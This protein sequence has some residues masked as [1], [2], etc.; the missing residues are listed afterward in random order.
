MC[1]GRCRGRPISRSVTA[2]TPRASRFATSSRTVSSILDAGT[3]IVGLSEALGGA[4]RAVPILLSHYHWD[5]VQGLPFF[6]QFFQP[7]WDISITGPPLPGVDAS[8]AA[9]LF[10][11]PHFPVPLAELASPPTVSFVESTAFTIGGFDV[12]ALRLTHPGGAF[13]Y[14]IQGAAGDLVYATDHEFG[15]DEADESLAAF[16]LNA[17]G[18]RARRALHARRAAGAQ[19][20]RT[21]AAGA[22]AR[23]SRRRAAPAISGCFTTSPDAP[24]RS[25]RRLKRGARRV[26]PATTVARERRGLHACEAAARGRRGHR[27]RRGRPGPRRR[28]PVHRVQRAHRRAA[29]RDAGAQDLRLAPRDDR[30]AGDGAPGHRARRDRRILAAQPR[31]QRRTLAVAAR[32]PSQRCSTIW[33][34][35]PRS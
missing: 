17:G 33:P 31:A 8:W 24:T 16:A 35:R 2:A 20:P 26:F 5:H 22:S 23:S 34:A 30:P 6:A 15:D 32:R 29:V 4:P 19:G 3:G 14:R 7:G 11:P 21:C 10:A 1:A 13:A 12:S 18:G 9:R 27:R 28:S 25:S